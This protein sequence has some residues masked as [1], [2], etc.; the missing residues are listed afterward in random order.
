MFRREHSTHFRTSVK[1]LRGPAQQLRVGFQ[2]VARRPCRRRSRRGFRTARNIRFS[3]ATTSVK[4]IA[5]LSGCDVL[6]FGVVLNCGG[7]GS[8]PASL[9]FALSIQFVVCATLSWSAISHA[10][11]VS[12]SGC[13]GVSRAGVGDARLATLFQPCGRS[14]TDRRGLADGRGLPRRQRSARR[15]NLARSGGAVRGSIDRRGCAASH[16]FSAAHQVS[17]SAPEA[18]CAGASR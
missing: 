12:I 9:F 5:G 11:T 6:C 1:L 13:S 14:R 7:V 16:P 15:A 3:Y 4:L 2:A 17:L 18:Q 10:G 8:R